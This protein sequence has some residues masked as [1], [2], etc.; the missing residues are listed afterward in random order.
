LRGVTDAPEGTSEVIFA[1]VS[2]CNS[3]SRSFR[4][5]SLLAPFGLTTFF[6]ALPSSSIVSAFL[7]NPFPSRLD[8]PSFAAVL[9]SSS[10]EEVRSQDDRLTSFTVCPAVCCTLTLPPEPPFDAA[11]FVAAI[12]VAEFL[13]PYVMIGVLGWRP[14]DDISSDTQ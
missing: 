1:V 5:E 11:V 3:P 4:A 9:S 7:F 12:V 6:A 10:E 13:R 2:C 14:W 8:T